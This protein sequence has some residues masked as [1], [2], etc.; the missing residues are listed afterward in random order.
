[1]EMNLPLEVERKTASI[2]NLRPQATD[3]LTVV[4]LTDD[5]REEVLSFLARRPI[6]T[7]GLAGFIHSNGIVSPHNRGQFYGCRNTKGQL[8]GVALIGHHTLFETD[9][10][11]A[12]AIFARLAQ[13]HSD[14]YMLLGEQEK[15]ERFWH[16]YGEGGREARLYCRELLFEQ[17]WP[18]QMME[19][20][21][22]MR[23]AAIEDLNL[24]LPAHAET[25]FYESGINP[26]EADLEGFGNRCAR[27]I[28]KGQTWVWIDKGKLLF[29]AEVL[30]DTPE[31]IYLEGIWVDCQERGKGYGLRCMLQLARDFLQRTKSICLLVNG[32]NHEAQVFYE[33]TGFRVISYYD[34]IFLKKEVN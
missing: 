18:V 24:I 19:P 16:Y 30:T 27:R 34:T 22:E 21:S 3:A 28:A 10:E 7:F 23:L 1:M 15:V 11:T 25:A 32:K 5:D 33:K 26:L 6:H 4:S 31:V 2:S 9:N 14:V 20:V 29:K 13:E 17:T 8:E 12:I